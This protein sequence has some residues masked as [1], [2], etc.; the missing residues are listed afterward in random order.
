MRYDVLDDLVERVPDHVRIDAAGAWARGRRRRVRSRV[1]VSGAAGLAVVL[2]ALLLTLMPRWG[3]GEFDPADGEVGVDGYPMVVEKGWRVQEL[4]A[5]PGPLAGVIEASGLGEWLVVSARGTSW[6]LSDVE[7]LDFYPPALS[8][9]GTRL[10]YFR[11]DAAYVL[12]DLVTG[13]SVEFDGFWAGDRVAKRADDFLMSS[14]APAFWAPDGDHLLVPATDSDGSERGLVV[15]GMDGSRR[16]LTFE[17]RDFGWPAGWLDS[18][19]LAY[20]T[21]QNKNTTATLASIAMNGEILGEVA[22]DVKPADVKN[23]SQWTGALSPDG[24]VLSYQSERLSGGQTALI[25]ARTGRSIGRSERDASLDTCPVS[26]RNERPTQF[27]PAD[28]A[29]P[30]AVRDGSQTILDVREDVGEETSVCSIWA[31]DALKGEAYPG[32]KRFL[33]S[34]TSW[35]GGAVLMLGAAVGLR[36][37]RF[38]RRQATP[39]E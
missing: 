34:L 22:L 25:E 21:S 14:Q 10:G 17:Q 6:R 31:T 19:T 16:D 3:T 38:L 28:E 4:P 30:E 11:E 20:L 1:A 27:V 13:E 15:L 9:D 26:W 37:W 2:V 23:S 5:R 32:D 8:H 24:S 39:I 36:R 33:G 18:S 7:D 29:N 12:H 35:V